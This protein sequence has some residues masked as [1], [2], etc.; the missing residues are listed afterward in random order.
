MG[1]NICTQG[2]N[3]SSDVWRHTK[4]SSKPETRNFQ[5]GH[6]A[7]PQH[8]QVFF[9]SFDLEIHTSGG[10]VDTKA[11]WSRLRESVTRIPNSSG[12]NGAASFGH[13]MGGYDCGYYGYLWSE[14][15]SSDMFTIFKQS[16]DLYSPVVG[17][18]YR[19]CILEPG[20]TLD[21][22]VLVRNFLGRDL[23]KTAFLISNG[24]Q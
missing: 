10:S 20:G 19:E 4:P 14:V 11:V 15:F 2:I 21:G 18:R 22:D 8:A 9:G 13:I 3:P 12:G 6:V 23:D 24:L 1:L 17:A 5:H 16:G 7:N